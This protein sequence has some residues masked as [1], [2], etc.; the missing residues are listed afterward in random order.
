MSEIQS[1][2][3]GAFSIPPH[4][5]NEIRRLQDA[6][7]SEE[8]LKRFIR[9]NPA[10][11]ETTQATA[12][13]ETEPQVP[14][15]DEPGTGMEIV[16]G[17]AEGTERAL[18]AAYSLVP[19]PG[20][21]EKPDGTPITNLNEALEGVDQFFGG[22][23]EVQK[24]TTTTGKV[25][26][27]LT[28]TL[29]GAIPAMKFVKTMGV[30]NV[31]AQTVF[32]GAVGDFVVGDEQLAKGMLNLIDM[33]PSELGGETADRVIEV[34]D[35]WATDP[36][37]GGY[38]DLKARTITALGGVPISAAADRLLKVAGIAAES[39][40]E[41]L[42]GFRD[43]LSTRLRG[44]DASAAVRSGDEQALFDAHSVI[45]SRISRDGKPRKGTPIFSE[46]YRLFVDRFNPIKKLQDELADGR[47][48]PI[49]MRPY[50]Q[51]RLQVSAMNKA[52]LF[53]EHEVRNFLTGEVV[54]PGLK[55]I[56][57]PLAGDGQGLREF[58]N[59]AVAKRA[60]ELMN[61]P[62]PIK[63][64]YEADRAALEK[65]V[66]E[67]G[68]RFEPIFRGVVDY[69]N[70][71]LTY[72][73]DSGVI[74]KEMVAAIKKAN[75]DYVPFFRL[76]DQDNPGGLAK[77]IYVPFREIKGSERQII[78]PL[79]SIIKNTY[80]FVQLAERN[81]VIKSLHDLANSSP[82]GSELVKVLPTK[83][84][85]IKIKGEELE[86]AIKKADPESDLLDVLRQY[87]GEAGGKFL[88]DEVN[89]F[90]V[91]SA[92]D[93]AN[94]VAY[95]NKGKRITLELDEEVATALKGMD[96]DSIN[97]LTK[98]FSIP[99]KTL[100]AG[101][102]LD[103]E[104]FV[105]NAMRDNVTAAVY[106]GNGFKPFLTDFASG[107]VSLK[108]K[109]KHY[110][111][112]LYGG[113]AQATLVSMDRQ[114]L[115]ENLAK[116][117]DSADMY[118]TVK[119]VVKSPLEILRV[120]TEFAENA[121]RIGEFKR[122]MKGGPQTK[123]AMQ[124]AGFGSREITLDFARRGAATKGLNMLSAFLNARIQGYDRMVRAMVNNPVRTNA[125]AGMFITTP[126]IFLWMHNNSTE[127]RRELYRAVPEWQ[128]NLFWVVVRENGD[129]VRIPKPF[130]LGVLYGSVPERLLDAWAGNR[131]IEDL[132]LDLWKAV[133]LDPNS[134][135]S[136]ATPTAASPI[137]EQATNYSFFRGRDLEP[138]SL[139]DPQ[140]APRP[141]DRYT[142][143][144][145]E[146]AK[147]ISELFGGAGIPVLENMSPIEVENYIGQW[148]GGLGRK[149]IELIVEP[150]GRALEIFP[151]Q[152]L[153]TK[154]LADIPFVKGFAIRHPDRNNQPAID[155]YRRSDDAM[156]WVNS[157]K[158]R[159]RELDLDRIKDL[160]DADG[161][162]V[163]TYIAIEDRI[164]NVRTKLSEFSA[165]IGKIYKH[166]TMSKTEKRINIDN[167]LI[168]MH[169]YAVKGNEMLDMAEEA[170]KTWEDAVGK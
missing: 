18:T 24:P 70:N 7:A 143:Y 98:I 152:N 16:R 137:V 49:N 38:D 43:T 34:I 102:I 88:P 100:R 52:N 8:H 136:T 13:T 163:A 97:L 39:G 106:S 84:K 111:D 135:I 125:R 58:S 68:E 164:R 80:A 69:Q 86:T 168:M 27:G 134:L 66:R 169:D 107:F 4:L 132:P 108:K 44:A 28:Q 40:A 147:K 31:F 83:S 45:G 161:G 50:E 48:L 51:V 37:N 53:L 119:N 90:R 109:D 54:G 158:K 19:V 75:E 105:R 6:G 26:S 144:T 78:D 59:Y 155:F 32:G 30:S 115:R 82:R 12:E 128:K 22:P 2:Q 113:G 117:M 122:A 123:E 95:M 41:A 47:E 29:W 72:L 63:T 114:Y 166:P 112:W 148:T 10:D 9:D 17:L 33:L 129:H 159:K 138:A 71:V 62:K 120:A 21:M 5:T 104:F 65:V 76:M 127:E 96:N 15:E 130:E 156:Q 154:T 121:T 92:P 133:G 99:A 131:K 160:M 11:E 55:K 145:S 85:P 20:G 149:F 14:G 118:T 151:E 23:I 46:M 1:Q 162:K 126:S 73:K 56:M 94:T 170:R 146:T 36:E 140:T 67:A 124:E 81:N 3:E 42:K 74:S 89:I 165:T 157:Y 25:T 35:E 141:Q 60:L 87:S 101:A 79:E 64:G 103:P 153:P 150:T 116:L 91:M 77:K 167:I 142:L 110:R 57:E 139:S 61:R 93:R